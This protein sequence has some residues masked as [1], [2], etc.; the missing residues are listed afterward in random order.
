VLKFHALCT[1]NNKI[2]VEKSETR[3][4]KVIFVVNFVENDNID[5]VHQKLRVIFF[6]YK[7]SFSIKLKIIE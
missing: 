7:L 4:V 2:F 3:L 6:L 1:S 5:I